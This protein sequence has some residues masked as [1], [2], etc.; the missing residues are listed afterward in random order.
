MTIIRP[1]NINRRLV[2]TATTATGGSPGNAGQIG[3]NKTPYC[4]KGLC[5]TPTLG[6]QG[7]G[8]GGCGGIFKSK[9]SFCGRT[10][11]CDCPFE[12]FGGFLICRASGVNW[13]VSPYSVEVSRSW[14]SRN[15]ANT[16]AQQVSGCTGW[17]VPSVS[18][19]GNPGF[20]CKSF[21]GP[22]PCFSNTCYWSSVASNFH[23]ACF[24]CFNRYG[25]GGDRCKADTLCV[26][27]FRC[28]TY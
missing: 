1:N 25:F 21:W 10:Q 17:F 16:R 18:Q 3:P 14:H 28:V 24:V 20:S 6:Q 5:L 15:D 12:N 13:V 4:A 9:E 22:S 19:L 26:R 7:Y 11:R 23:N 2:G 27:A 8:G